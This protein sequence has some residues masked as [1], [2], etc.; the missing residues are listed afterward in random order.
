MTGPGAAGGSAGVGD[1]GG[2][3]EF[4]AETLARAAWSRLAEPG[5]EMAGAVLSALGAVD[6][7]DWLRTAVGAG[8]AAGSA[9]GAAG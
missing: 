1:A 3:G 9:A 4:D 2:A 5:D 6:A 7:L 8:P